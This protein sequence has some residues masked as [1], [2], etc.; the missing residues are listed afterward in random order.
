MLASVAGFAQDKLN[1]AASEIMQQYNAMSTLSA[2]TTAKARA[3]AQIDDAYIAIVTFDSAAST[4]DIDALGLDVI[5]V[6]D[7]MALVVLPL[8]DV[9]K[10]VALDS[11]KEICFGD[12]SDIKMDKARA[13]TGVDEVHAGTGLDHGYTGK[14]IIVGLYDTGLDPQHANFKDADGNTRVIG[15]AN[16]INGRAT[17][18]EGSRVTTFTTDNMDETHGTHVLGILAG[19]FNGEAT[20]SNETTAVPYYGVAHGADIIVTCGEL[21]DNNILAGVKYAVDKGK[22]LGKPVVFNLSIGKNAGSHD[23]TSSF[24]RMLDSYAQDAFITVSSGNEGDVNM[25]VAKTFTADDKEL[26]TYVYPNLSTGGKPSSVTNLVGKTEFYASDNRPFK[27]R[28]VVTNTSG[29]SINGEYLIDGSE[30]SVNIGGS[31]YPKY[32]QIDN[33]EKACSSSS[34]LQVKTGVNSYSDRY[35]VEITHKLD[36]PAGTTN[37]LGFIIEGEEGQT[38]RGYTTCTNTGSSGYISTFSSRNGLFRGWLDGT[39]NGTINDMACGQNTFAIG[40]F[41]TRKTW[42]QLTGR[43]TGYSAASYNEGLISPFSSYGTLIDERNLPIICAPGCGIVSS[44]SHYYI[45][46]GNENENTLSAKLEEEGRFGRI[47]YWGNMQ[48][49]SMAAPFAAGVIALWLEANPQ[50]SPED[51]RAIMRETAMTDANVQKGNA[52]QWGAGKIDALAGIKKALSWSGIN[53]VVSGGAGFV[54]SGANG[55]YEIFA[56]GAKS[57]DAMLFSL[58]GSLVARENVAG[59]SMRFAPAVAPGVYILKATA[60]GKTESRK[61]IIR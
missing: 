27:L 61:I 52:V 44:Y 10:V 32:I 50:L 41:N 51:V 28:V 16:V 29:S 9:E 46:R 25:G 47:N 40:S 33:F 48:G 56:A 6:V 54:I 19:S 4:S 20:V 2:Q 58:S 55:E 31:G 7:D 53:D 38:V 42:P 3:A 30:A 12:R 18:Y 36:F 24:C 45:N 8:E 39:P 59:E 49:T 15:I 34:Y 26:K 60:S 35:F 23:G 5:D 43:S 17:T 37:Y 14:G 57:I 11:V 13:A 22:E 1:S 21:L